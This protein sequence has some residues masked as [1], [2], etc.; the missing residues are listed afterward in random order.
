V[1][2]RNSILSFV[3]SFLFARN[4]GVATIVGLVLLTGCQEAD[5]PLSEDGSDGAA[6]I[7]PDGGVVSSED[8]VLTLTVR[9][10]SLSDELEVRVA[11]SEDPPDVFGPAYRISPNPAL[12]L[13]MTLTYRYPLPAQI[14]N[15]AIAVILR[16]DFERGQGRW[17]A[18]PT[19]FLD[20]EDGWISASFA[21][22]APFVALTDD[23]N[24]PAIESR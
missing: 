2:C 14:E 12:A 19:S 7:G 15:L 4:R 18:L 5:P 3:V 24:I 23:P 22:L 16:D 20:E 21:E 9:P 6:L 17:Y 8:G 1:D 11:A 10:D 13:N